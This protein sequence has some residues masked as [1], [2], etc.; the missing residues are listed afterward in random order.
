MATFGVPASLTRSIALDRSPATAHCA[1][2]VPRQRDAS[3][4]LHLHPYTYYAE[5]R[6]HGKAFIET[7][8]KFQQ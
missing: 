6:P 8:S 7:R 2:P 1:N 5:A 4:L 3:S